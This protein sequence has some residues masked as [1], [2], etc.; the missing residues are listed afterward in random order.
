LLHGCSPADPRPSS[1][2]RGGD[3][4]EEGVSSCNSILSNGRIQNE[5]LGFCCACDLQ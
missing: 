3:K 2:G 5:K 1:T 4:G